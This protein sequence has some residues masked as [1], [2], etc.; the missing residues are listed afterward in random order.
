[1]SKAL[2]IMM[3]IV[4]ALWG[5]VATFVLFTFITKVLNFELKSISPLDLKYFLKF[6]LIIIL[7]LFMLSAVRRYLQK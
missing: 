6:S 2:K 1:M 7:L 5:I 4:A 3:I